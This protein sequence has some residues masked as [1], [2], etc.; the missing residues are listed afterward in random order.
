M[1]LIGSAGEVDAKIGDR[2]TWPYWAPE[3]ERLTWEIADF[4]GGSSYSPSGL[5]GTP[6]VACRPI[7]N[8][9]PEWWRQYV[10]PDGTVDWCG[11]SIA[12]AILATA[13]PAEPT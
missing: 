2:F 7:A 12:T 10:K 9:V 1:I 8:I 13:Q 5:G 3:D 4:P 11:D 6:T